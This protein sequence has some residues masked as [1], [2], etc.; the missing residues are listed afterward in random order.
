MKN[1]ENITING[2]FISYE[3]ANKIG[4]K[5]DSFS[6]Y[7]DAVIS[8]NQTRII[9]KMCKAIVSSSGR[10]TVYFKEQESGIK[11]FTLSENPDIT[12]NISNEINL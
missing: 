10:E 11:I 2:N 3:E 4:F 8:K 5:R 12:I 6:Y 9:I 7:V 1:I